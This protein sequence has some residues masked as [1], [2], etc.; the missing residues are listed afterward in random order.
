MRHTLRSLVFA[1]L[2]LALSIP[3]AAQQV[4]ADPPV[5]APQPGIEVQARGPIHE[6]FAQPVSL[7]P[8]PGPLV[9]KAPP[10]PI[11]EEPPEQWPQ[12]NNVQWIGG[13]WAWDAD[14]NEFLW[15]SG[16]YR[17]APP[18]RHFI[19]G[20]WEN[21]PDGWRWV[22]GYWAPDG[23]QDLPYVPQ[24]PAP[25]DA[26]G[27]S[28]PPPD[29]NSFY[30]PGNW[31]YQGTQ[32]AWRPGS[33]QPCQPG[34]VWVP[35]QYCWTPSG[36]VFVSG[37]WDYPLD[38]RGLLFAPVC[39]TQPLWQTPGW[40]YQPNYLVD[41]GPLL[42][43]LFV[44]PRWGHY[45]F[46]DYYGNAYAS[47][48]FT[49]W[50][51]YGARAYDPLF[52]YYRWRNRGNPGW[53]AGLG[54]L[55]RDRVAGRVPLPPRTLA[56]QTALLR[57]TTAGHLRMITPVSQFRAQNLRLAQATAAQRGVQRT[58]AQ[59]LRQLSVSRSQTEAV[60]GPARTPA[61]RLHSAGVNAPRTTVAPRAATAVRPPTQAARVVPR[62]PAAP[63]K[64]AV[65]QPRAHATAPR[66]ATPASRPPA[67]QRQ[68]A[69]SHSRPP[70]A[71][72]RPTAA[73]PKTVA[74]APTAMQRQTTVS[75]GRPPAAQPRPAPAR[76]KTAAPAPKA[77]V[78][79][80]RPPAP[81]VTH[82]LRPQPARPA[83]AARAQPAPRHAAPAR[84]APAHG[85]GGHSTAHGNGKH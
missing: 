44:R 27:P 21:T 71:Q 10:D 57:Q 66:L 4:A 40:C 47:R 77:H 37:Y 15:V 30:A 72:P 11:P 64:T 34:W 63:P 43:A 49:P 50:H 1:S 48:G 55:Y 79:A 59:R 35:A 26:A 7:Q 73:R 70:A 76:P 12:G 75:H 16:T 8:E 60:R 17:D 22:P 68:A 42:N 29:D 74:P 13:Y 28:V 25:P 9:P 33:W 14:R 51:A 18:G 41:C 38:A 61:T 5:P 65:A 56:Q 3:A 52:G 85:G 67:V 23:Q 81:R 2:G 54:Q 84:A 6:A 19:P 53:H 46:G 24:P 31:V 83:P 58:N 62:T 20:Y 80:A 69:T 78:A 36:C 45:Y 32:F 82:T 39:F